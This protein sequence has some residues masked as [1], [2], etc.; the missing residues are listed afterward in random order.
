[1]TTSEM[2][3][4]DIEQIISRINKLEIKLLEISTIIERISRDINKLFVS[5]H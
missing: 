3:E 4:K 1:M 5:V 2:I